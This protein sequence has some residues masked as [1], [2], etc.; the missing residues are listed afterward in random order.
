MPY[1]RSGNGKISLLAL[2][3]I[4]LGGFFASCGGSVI[5]GGD[6]PI[7]WPHRFEA[8]LVEEPTMRYQ[9]GGDDGQEKVAM[10]LTT[11]AELHYRLRRLEYDNQF[12]IE[13]FSTRCTQFKQ[14]ET[15]EF[16]CRVQGRWLEESVIQCKAGNH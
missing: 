4:V 7:G 11:D 12:Y 10:T 5:N 16:T 1:G 8:T 14:G 13:C 9:R 15:H 3:V 6:V 2:V